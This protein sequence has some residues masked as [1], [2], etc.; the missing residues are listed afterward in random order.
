MI[1]RPYQEEAVNK[2][3]WAM[4]L[5]GN[6]LIVIG[7]GGGKSHIIAEFV[8]RLNKPVLVLCPS[9]EILEQDIN[10]MSAYLPKE[11]IG[12][13]SA[14]LGQKTIKRVTFGTLQSAYKDP[15]LF[16]GFDVVIYDEA[17]LHNPKSVEGMSNTL[18]RAA[19]IKKVFGLTGTPYRL[20]HYYERW[21][22][23]SWML[24]SISTIKMINRYQSR[25]WM[26]MLVVVN[27]GDLQEQGF[28][29]K[30]TYKNMSL[31]KHEE[32]KTNKGQSEFDLEDFENKVCNEYT[33]VAKFVSEL[34]H[35][36]TLVFCSSVEQSNALQALIPNSEVVTSETTAKKRQQAVQD[37][38]DSKFKVLLGVGIFTM[39]FDVPDLDSIVVLRPTK[40][41]RLW[42]QV[43][44][45]GTRIAPGK[46]TCTVYDFVSNVENLGTL[47]SIKVCKIED[48][49]N[50]VSDAKPGGFHGKKLF[51]FEMPDPMVRKYMTRKDPLIGSSS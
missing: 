8:H 11:D 33:S 20:D 16:E 15:A 6:D 18:F 45:R 32:L 26:R 28:L 48:K 1:L 44:G 10:K 34:P 42:G 4:G 5:E 21:G 37:F 49:W 25:F 47:E 43:L 7:Q 41:L 31:V 36:K 2:M 51:E 38:K 40:S 35:K 30:L 23:Q 12:V 22:R 27:I 14:S 17:D 19:G 29:T 50:V 39:G 46:T 24:K 9:K 13:F 3:M